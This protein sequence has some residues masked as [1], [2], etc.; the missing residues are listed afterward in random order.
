MRKKVRHF[1]KKIILKILPDSDRFRSLAYRPKF[2]TWLKQ[3]S[4]DYPIFDTRF[5]MYE[6]LNREI[7]SNDPIHYLEFGVYKGNSIKAFSSINTHLNSRFVGFDT[8]TGLPE[9]WV[10]LT[11]KV[12]KKT[13]DMGGESPQ[14][15]DTRVLFVPGLFQNTLPKFI[16]NYNSKNQLVIHNDSDLYSSTLYMLTCLSNIIIPGTIIIFDEFY[17]VM[18][19]FRALEDYC[20]SYMCNYAVIAATHSHIQIAIK[21]L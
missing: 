9:D 10:E 16:D 4:G 15:D 14:S 18:H 7:I 8:F 17:S 13:F 21:I 5:L 20:I 19:E 1:S 11:K 6:Y 2:E 3:H 12:K